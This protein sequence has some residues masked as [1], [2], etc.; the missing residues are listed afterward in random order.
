[1]FHNLFPF[2]AAGAGDIGGGI[3]T[4][5]QV[6]VDFF[7]NLGI[8]GNLLL[9]LLSLAMGFILSGV[10]G[11]ERE[12]HGHPAGLRT[13]ILIGAGSTVITLISIYGFT[14]AGDSP[15]DP[16]RLAAQ[17]VPGIGFLGAGTIIQTGTDIKGLTTAT[18]IWFSMAIGLAC[19]TGRF[20]L[21]ILSTVLAM[22]VLV[23]FRRVER[24]A[25][26]RAPKITLV[27]PSDT[28][29]LR[30]AH[31]VASRFGVNI[32]DSESQ[33]VVI[34][35]YSYIRV[36]LNCAFTS[37]KNIAAFTDALKDTIKPLEFRI[38]ADH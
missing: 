18:T 27:V 15:R 12:Y 11:F 32:R 23:A 28:P 34:N 37:R 29:I 25:N 31:L 24:F 19:G 4:I 5:D 16:L 26:R 9:A 38:S 10:I 7:N 13:H 1:M 21:A 6:I 14:Y 2:L 17:I 35:G 20:V 8:W 33:L 36:E 22:F 3:F 30:D